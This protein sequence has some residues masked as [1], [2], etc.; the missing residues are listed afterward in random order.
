MKWRIG[1]TIIMFAVLSLL[2]SLHANHRPEEPS[3]V[4]PTTHDVAQPE[5]SPAMPIDT[6]SHAERWEITA[7]R[8]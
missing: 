3:L 8:Q 1:V 5:I 2:S 6:V 7:H 4:S